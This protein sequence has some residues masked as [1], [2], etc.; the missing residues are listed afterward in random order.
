MVYDNIDFHNVEALT[1]VDG[2]E[3]LRIQRVPEEV[4]EKMSENGQTMLLS[5]VANVEIRFILESDEVEIS[6]SKDGDGPLRMYVF[7]GDFQEREFYEISNEISTFKLT[8]SDLLKQLDSK[9][10][11]QS[12]YHPEW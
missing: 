6:L 12:S 3:G 4:R 7:W 9:Y 10:Y 5:P 11:G 2:Q 8:I 1:Q